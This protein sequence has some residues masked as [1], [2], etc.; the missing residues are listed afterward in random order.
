MNRQP[1]TCTSLYKV[2]HQSSARK[3][4]PD[5]ARKYENMTGAD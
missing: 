2:G 4:E 3:Y 5:V 1:N